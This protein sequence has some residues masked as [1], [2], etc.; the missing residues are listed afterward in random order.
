MERDVVKPN[1]NAV[2]IKSQSNEP[3]RK[4]DTSTA[5]KNSNN[6]FD[7]LNTDFDLN[8]LRQM[9]DHST[10]LPQC[11]SAYRSNIAGFGIDIR[12]REDFNKETDEMKKEFD[13]VKNIIDLL[14]IEMDTKEVF[15]NI[16]ESRETYGIAYLEIIRDFKGNVCQIEC[17]R[18]VP[19]IKKSVPFA[20]AIDV[21]YYYNGDTVIRKRKFC[22]YMQ[23]KNGQIVYFK[24]FGDTRIMDNR[25]GTYLNG[26]EGVNLDY[27]ANEILEFKIGTDDYGK[28]RWIGQVLGI[29]GSRKAERLN[30]NYFENG[31]HTPLAIVV[32]GGT[33]SD[34]SYNK[35]REYMNEI[36]GEA[37]QHAFLVLEVENTE[38]LHGFE[39]SKKP[40]VE[41]KDM[42]SI[43]Q[44]DELFQSYLE[45]S[46]K[47]VQSA[48]RLPDLYVGYT[49][50]FNRATA[51]TAME[52]TER[53]VFQPERRSLAWIINNKLLNGYHLKY[54]EVYLK[55]PDL[56]NPDDL[57]KILNI[58]ERAGGLPPNK[59]KDLTYKFLGDSAENY[60]GTWG[61]IPFAY[62]KSV[63]TPSEINIGQQLDTQI[64]KAEGNNDTDVIPIMKAV[65]DLLQNM[66][67]V[68]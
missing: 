64:Q 34:A 38:A 67:E 17:I 40:S 52:I 31:R 47:K 12:Y 63:A 3:I 61:D 33:L 60:E 24:E 32:Q 46:R 18:D 11:I 14:N 41:L 30:N 68:E 56:S 1:I 57:A 43:L 54:V 23:E 65:R 28:V 35:L 8:G 21:E 49:T 19:T 59:A 25:N 62:I 22:K 2:I 45:N 58:T 27:H 15:E 50:D 53:Q 55:G 20:P 29:D 37:G 5:I 26:G 39:D 66:Q 6:S 16:V 48:F 10:I 51:Q 13:Y 9:V 4:A 7:W 42:A 44:T 36:K